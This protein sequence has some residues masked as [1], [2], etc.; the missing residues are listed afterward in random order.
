MDP[1]RY[2]CAPYLFI[3]KGVIE[4]AVVAF[5]RKFVVNF[6]IFIQI[7]PNFAFIF[8]DFEPVTHITLH[9]IESGVKKFISD[10]IFSTVWNWVQGQT[11]AEG[12]FRKEAEGGDVVVETN[13]SALLALYG[14]LFEPVDIGDQAVP[15]AFDVQA[16]GGVVGSIQWNVLFLAGHTLIGVSVCINGTEIDV[17]LHTGVV[18]HGE[19][20]LALVA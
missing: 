14:S 1:G 8:D 15:R 18:D 13:R 16:V 20:I 5:V 12:V 11:D 19:T 4:N 17:S 6:T 2:E 10:V 7:L 9:T 3:G